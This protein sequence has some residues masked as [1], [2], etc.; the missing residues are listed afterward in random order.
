M[1]RIKITPEAIYEHNRRTQG[2]RDETGW[3]CPHPERIT[4]D[5]LMGVLKSA[6]TATEDKDY[7]L[8]QK[9]KSD[10]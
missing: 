9:P 1:A 6:R 2:F 5:Q 3:L 4:E 7:I 10:G 8:V